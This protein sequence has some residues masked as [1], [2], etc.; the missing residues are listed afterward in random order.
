MDGDWDWAIPA[1]S[2]TMQGEQILQPE[3]VAAMLRGMR[4]AGNRRAKEFGCAR[5]TVPRHLSEGGT[6][7][8]RK[9]VRPTAFDGLDDWLRERFFPHGSSRM[10]ISTCSRCTGKPCAVAQHVAARLSVLRSCGLEFGLNRAE[11]GLDS[12]AKAC[13][14]RSSFSELRPKR[15]APAA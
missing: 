8:F 13:W 11:P 6:V 14:A 7:P 15:R 10:T 3:E 2:R 12:K 4:L 1:L 9:P 5:N